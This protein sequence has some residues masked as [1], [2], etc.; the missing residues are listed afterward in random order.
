MLIEKKIPTEETLLDNLGKIAYTLDKT[1]LSRLEEDYGVLPFDENYN[2]GENG[3]E[4]ITYASN[5]RILRIKKCVVDKDERVIDCF[6]NVLGVF[7]GSEDTLALVFKR[8][9]ETAEM[10]FVVKNIGAGKNEKSAGNIRLLADSISGNFPGT[11]VEIISNTE[12]FD[13]NSDNDILGLGK[14]H[15]ISVLSGIPSEKSEKFTCQGIEKLLNGIVPKAE[16]ENYTV[17]FLAEA[18]SI[19]EI[20]S[21][22]NGFEE[23]ATAITPFTGY[24]Y[25]TGSNSTETTGEMESLSHSDGVSHAISKTHSVNIGVNGSRFTSVTKSISLGL[26]RVVSSALGAVGTA[27]GTLVCPGAGSVVG[28]VVGGKIGEALGSFVPDISKSNTSGNS[29][30]ASAG[31]GFSYGRTDTTSEQDTK[32]TGSNHSVSLGTT[33]N[34]TYSYKSYLVKDLLEKIE[35]TIKRIDQSKS[36]GLWRYAAYVLADDANTT[37]NVTNFLKSI[38][39]GDES[40]IEPSFIQTWIH[41][42][43]NERKPFD[44]IVKYV[45]HFCHPV[46]GNMA[47]GTWVLPTMNVS[48]TELANIFSFPKKSVAGLPILECAEFGRNI[49]TYDILKEGINLP[50]G[51]IFHMNRTES[52][53]VLLSKNSL[54]SHTFITGSTGSGKS[55]TIYKILDEAMSNKV[56]FLVVEP[57]KGEYK[58]FFGNLDNVSVYGTNQNVT[59]LLRLDPFSFPEDIHVLE[60]LDRLVEIFNVCWPMYAAMPA[61]LKNAVEK[62]YEDCGW[63][64]T[65]STNELG[66]NLFPNFADVARNIKFIIDS[67]EYDTENKGAYKGSL[68]TR[69]NSLTNGIN[70]L[71]FNSDE[72]PAKHL[73]DSNVIVDLSRVGSSE[74]KSLIMGMLILKLQEY[75]MTSGRMNSGLRH[76]TV[77]EEAHNLLKRTS[78]EQPVEGGNLLGKSVE[79]LANSIA[80]MRTYGEGFIIADQAPGLL[81]MSV[82]RNTNTKIILRLPDQSD[83]EL[84]GRAANLNENQITELAKL[85]CGVAA[86][87]QN[88]WIQPVLCKVDRVEYNEKPYIMPDNKP[89]E[90]L[91]VDPGKVLEIAE[92]LSK[93][94]A[95]N[96]EAFVNEINPILDQMKIACSVRVSIFKMLQNPPK[97]PR[98]T[99][100]APIM[101]ALFPNVRKTIEKAYSESRDPMEW[102]VAGENV[103]SLTI[104]NLLCKDIIQAIVTDYVYNELGRTD[105]VELWT[106]E[107]LR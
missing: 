38:T 31:Y 80:E 16:N 87:Y 3:T 90:K 82:I 60:H 15:A 42:D 101:S 75:R 71:I 92:L 2:H 14:A 30:G 74:T 91:T 73:F 95:K 96:R 36:N 51:K 44:E 55:N 63:N 79:M 23:L 62:A 53:N 12:I 52:T 48:T 70:G 11:E 24:Q 45:T 59:P 104:Q 9:R 1:Y 106:K 34:T 72:I 17:V 22:L 93:G 94:E 40:F 20:R 19:V 100:L 88:E 33:E 32:T 28:G 76:I 66:G 50:L 67:S 69:L 21:I 105:D 84:V 61:V 25:Q 64:L 78:T 46:F 6:K 56:N 85:P 81:D 57:A 41:E 103:L 65:E 47:D 107:G 29:I 5:I 68:L 27:V 37:V 8:T 89:A 7:G 39:Q 86:V 102:T 26:S 58:N 4:Q 98:M 97:E 83:R 99:R 49:T 10:Y 77:L 43:G 35:A 54:A 13:N 18:I